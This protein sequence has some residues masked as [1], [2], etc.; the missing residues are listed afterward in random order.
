MSL[1]D[2]VPAYADLIR[3]VGTF[4]TGSPVSIVLLLGQDLV[5]TAA[6]FAAE[7][8]DAQIHALSV[9]LP[10]PEPAGQTTGPQVRY[11]RVPTMA[12]RLDYVA[13][14]P[15]PQVIVEAG[16]LRH[17]H[18]LSNL[19]HL[20]YSVRAGGLYL[21]AELDLA[22]DPRYADSAE[23]TVE[24][25]LRRA[26]RLRRRGTPA[27]W[28]MEEFLQSASTISVAPDHAVVG[29]AVDHLYKL[30]ESEAD[31]VLPA[32]YGPAWG[33]SQVIAPARTFTS[34]ARISSYGTGPFEARQTFEIPPMRLRQYSDVV[35]AAGSIAVHGDHVLP[36]TFRHLHQRLLAHRHLVYATAHYARLKP[37]WIASPPRPLTGHYYLLDTEHPGH[38][39]HVTTEVLARCW[40]WRLAVRDDPDL[41]PLVSTIR[42]P[43]RL[44]AYQQEIFAA[45]DIPIDRVEV[46]S[47]RDPVRVE[48]LSAATPQFENPYYIDPDIAETWH[49]LRTAL[50]PP[51]PRKT[52]ARIFVSRR[53]G[54]KRN[55]HQTGEIERFFAERGF[56]VCFPEDLAYAEQARLFAHA[57]IIAGFG[58]SGL[59]TMVL[60]PQA[61][62]ILLSGDGYNAENEH[63]IAAVNGN[64]LHYFWGPSDLRAGEGISHLEAARA[65]FHFS[66]AEHRRALLELT[67]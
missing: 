11:A 56:A 40:G 9:R 15:P 29:K 6:A 12:S 46:V 57:E 36:D 38:F 28:A 54:W 27:G 64:D 2:R 41:R 47:P 10:L 67:A 50:V 14:T 31:E 25:F 19:R 48:R 18:K 58:G 63:L 16:D 24:S 39:G 21:A 26:R 3:D 34:R 44:P 60:A 61:R 5:A 17:R 7:F 22:A 49:Q 55:C 51:G 4:D 30:R 33:T 32:R 1:A 23:H 65:N 37:T 35:C 8:P 62:V 53:E 52:P 13:R 45:L 20:F 43:A 59:F 66:L 42:G